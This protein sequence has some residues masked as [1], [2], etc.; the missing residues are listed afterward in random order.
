L[1]EQEATM[2]VGDPVSVKAG[3]LE[4]NLGTNIGGVR[5]PIIELARGLDG[6]DIVCV[7]WDNFTLKRLPRAIIEKNEQDG[8]DWRVGWLDLEDVE[9]TISAPG[10]PIG[11]GGRAL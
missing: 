2:K 11:K 5:G 7:E 4:P 8:L 10:S 6:R 9:R 3:S 1:D